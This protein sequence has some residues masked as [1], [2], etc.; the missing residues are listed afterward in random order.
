[1]KT[2]F[3]Q[4]FCIDIRLAYGSCTATTK[5]RRKR[6]ERKRRAVSTAEWRRMESPKGG[7][8]RG[9][10]DAD[11]PNQGWV[12]GECYSFLCW[13]CFF[14]SPCTAYFLIIMRLQ[15]FLEQSFFV[16]QDGGY[17]DLDTA[18]CHKYEKKKR[19]DSVY[20]RKDE[21]ERKVSSEFWTM[22]IVGGNTLKTIL[23]RK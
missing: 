23:F 16:C 20:G 1:M 8:G 19:T 5:K 14:C 9:V 6:R 11:E 22:T 15:I 13:L 3:L 10:R 18:A 2:E 4:R 21:G 17:Q 7:G 12:N